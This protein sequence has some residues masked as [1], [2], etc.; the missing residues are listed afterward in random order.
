VPA[1]SPD[2]AGA[3]VA[4]NSHVQSNVVA[5]PE[6]A[7]IRFNAWVR[8]DRLGG[9]LLQILENRGNC[10]IK[11]EKPRVLEAFHFCCDRVLSAIPN[12]EFGTAAV[13]YPYSVAIVPP[14]ISNPAG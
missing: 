9:I 6:T 14:A 7:I 5:E 8:P 1:I 3:N 10:R 13:V 2:S 12:L 11:H 4:R